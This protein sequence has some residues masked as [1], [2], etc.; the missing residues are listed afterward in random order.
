[1]TKLHTLCAQCRYRS[2]ENISVFEWRRFDYALNSIKITD[3]VFTVNSCFEI[4]IIKIIKPPSA[5]YEE[6]KVFG[7]EGTLCY[8]SILWCD[9]K[10]NN[11]GNHVWG[12]NGLKQRLSSSDIMLML[13]RLRLSSQCVLIREQRE[14]FSPSLTIR[15]LW[16]LAGSRG[17]GGSFTGFL[18]VSSLLH[19]RPNTWAAGIINQSADY[20]L[21]SL[22]AGKKT[23]NTFNNLVNKGLLL[24]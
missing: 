3:V 1:M 10:E 17:W 2:E 14:G 9:I 11:R 24:M 5:K 4:I 15:P 19:N 20:L 23:E 18:T 16:D 22:L 8:Y 13:L 12:L 7:R 6:H 21:I